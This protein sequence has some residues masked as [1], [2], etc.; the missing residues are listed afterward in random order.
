MSCEGPNTTKR[1]QILQAALDTIYEKK[2]SGANLREI[3]SRAGMSQ[4]HL[5]YYYPSKQALYLDLLDY[6]LECF[7]EERRDVLLSSEAR[8]LLKLSFFLKQKTDVIQRK[9]EMDV[10]VDF[11][12]QG[13]SDPEIQEKIQGLYDRW[14]D[15]IA[16]VVEEGVQSG[17]FSTKYAGLIPS[18]LVSLMDGAALQYLIDGQAFDLEEYFSAAYEMVLGLL[19]KPLSS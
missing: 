2:I 7:V 19:I 9:K 15:D 13:T 17:L 1:E 16:A 8:P 14:R 4:G 18:L 6:L 12:V 10:F 3:A 11:W 5:H